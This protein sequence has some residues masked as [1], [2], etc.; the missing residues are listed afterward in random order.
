M[1][2]NFAG[3]KF[4]SN[5]RKSTKFNPEKNLLLTL[6]ISRNLIPLKYDKTA[7]KEIYESLAQGWTPFLFLPGERRISPVV[8]PNFLGIC[9]RLI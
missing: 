1:E 2:L 7:T 9:R 4:R 8:F 3:N 6:E 5:S